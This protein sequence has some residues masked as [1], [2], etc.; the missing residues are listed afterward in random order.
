MDADPRRIL[1]APDGQ[2]AAKPYELLRQAL[3][4]SAKVAVAEYAWSGRER[5]GML[6]VCAGMRSC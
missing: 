3:A 2:V 6:R 4:R 5:L 1:L